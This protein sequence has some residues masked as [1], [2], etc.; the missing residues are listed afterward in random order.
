[1]KKAKPNS[2]GVVSLVK[3]QPYSEQIESQLEELKGL[4]KEG[5]LDEFI[6]VFKSGDEYHHMFSGTD[7]TYMLI[8]QIEAMKQHQIN[9]LSAR[10]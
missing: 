9:R 1:M 7:N 3:S 8:G 2:M 4:H 5:K 10:H 6:C